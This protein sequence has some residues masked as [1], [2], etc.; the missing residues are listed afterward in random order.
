V[1]G[2]TG[3]PWL[4]RLRSHRA[5]PVLVGVVAFVPAVL[6]WFVLR[7]ADGDTEPPAS[8]ST[9]S[10]TVPSGSD[11]GLVAWEGGSGY[12]SGFARAVEAGWSDPGFF[13]IG[14]WFETAYNA[15]AYKAMG[16]NTMVALAHDGADLGSIGR[17]TG[18]FFVP[19]Q[20]EWTTAEVGANPY[21]VGWLA[22]DECDMTCAD[23]VRDQQ[24]VVDRLRARGDGRFVYSNY[25][26]AALGTWWNPQ[27]MPAL[28]QMVDVASADLYFWTDPNLP[29]EAPL[30]PFWPSGAVVRQS[31]AYGWTVDRMWS[32]QSSTDRQPTWAFV[33]DGHPAGE[34]S[35]PTITPEQMEGAV[36]ASVVRDA[37]GIVIFNHS[38]GGSC[39]SFHVLLDCNPAM[40]DRVTA[41]NAK[42]TSLAPVL[43]SP[44][45]QWNAGS[46]VVTMLKKLDGSWYLFAM[47]T[48]TGGTG[49]RTLRFPHTITGTAQVLFENRT[50]TVTNSTLTDTFTNTNTIHIYKLTP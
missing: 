10:T 6:T 14:V 32:F 26:K 28:T 13:P 25:G 36:W 42:I 47:P 41:M 46:G 48:M 20:D 29:Y 9:T 4:A 33:E 15:S 43:N 1:T 18:M 8:T 49:Q 22:S 39:F 16:F 11:P 23:P 21:V 38:F 2:R 30:S 34:A 7:P 50:L 40:R 12:W 19:Q 31:P 37:R 5:F 24:A 45:Y 3:S 44:S 35:A 27:N 17:S